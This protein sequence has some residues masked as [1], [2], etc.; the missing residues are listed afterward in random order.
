MNRE[1][2]IDALRYIIEPYTVNNEAFSHLNEDTDFIHDLQINSAH[3]VD[4]V[5]DIEEKFDVVIDNPDMERMLN[6]GAA[7]DIIESKLQKKNGRQ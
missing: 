6:V 4:I 2:L 3:L 5:L 1:E 7:I